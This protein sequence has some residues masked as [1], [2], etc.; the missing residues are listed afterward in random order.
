MS[1]TYIRY[2]TPSEFSSPLSTGA[3]SF[4]FL[5]TASAVNTDGL[6]DTAPSAVSTLRNYNQ[7]SGTTT[8]FERQ[9][10][11]NVV[12]YAL[13]PNKITHV[14]YTIDTLT[15]DVTWNHVL[16]I[17]GVSVGSASTGSGNVA[18]T[19]FTIGSINTTYHFWAGAVHTAAVWVNRRLSAQDAA[20]LAAEPYAVFRP[21]ARRRYFIFTPAAAD[22]GSIQQHIGRAIG[23]GFFV[24]R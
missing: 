18:W 20:W 3:F 7:E 13:T 21:I 6:F 14:I 17:D 2:P 12:T 16:Y 22:V 8:G 15:D 24:G 9:G 11:S 5:V 10:G 1:S 4:A 19:T 23:R